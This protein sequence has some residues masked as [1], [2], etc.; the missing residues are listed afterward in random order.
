MKYLQASMLR[1][2]GSMHDSRIWRNSTVQQIMYN[3]VQESAL[4]GHE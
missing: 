1:G 2:Q 4:L 3:N